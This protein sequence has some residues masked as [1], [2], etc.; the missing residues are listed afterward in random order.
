[1]I[2][3]AID[4]DGLLARIE[5]ARVRQLAVDPLLAVDTG[6]LDA[7]AAI[8]E[9]VAL[10]RRAPTVRTWCCDGTAW[11]DRGANAVL[12]LAIV[13][14]AALAAVRAGGTAGLALRLG[15]GGELLVD[16]AK[17]RAARALWH[18]CAQRLGIAPTPEFHARS[19]RHLGAHDDVDTHLVHATLDGFAA[20][21]GG[22]DTLA[23]ERHDLRGPAAAGSRRWARNIS[24]V[25]REECGL[26]R[27]D[28]PHR[29]R[30]T[31]SRRSPTRSRVGHG[32]ASWRSSRPAG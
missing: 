12:E 10:H 15:L 2:D 13:V 24:H 23:I 29:R 28:D 17:L 5:L 8:A 27:V 6:R 31:R 32:S 16:V 25:L 20:A 18:A 26:D 11:S 1:M 4:A 22:A 14:A 21:L 3:G 30:A 7:D 19:R 9:A